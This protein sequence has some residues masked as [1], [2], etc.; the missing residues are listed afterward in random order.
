M[1]YTNRFMIILITISSL[2]S[3]QRED[4]KLIIEPKWE[5]L[6][7]NTDSIK[8]F[9]GKWVLAGSII[10]KKKSSECVTL[11][12]IHLKWDG[13]FIENLT[14]SLYHKQPNKDFHP[15]Q[16]FLICDGIWNKKKQMLILNFDKHCSLG[17]VNT[18]YLVLT[19]PQTQES[20]IKKG[21]FKLVNTC[22]PHQFKDYLGNQN[23]HLSLNSP[24][25]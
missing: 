21:S 20:L 16:D 1:K 11:H 19:I 22:L 23:I 7:T 2:S 13:P 24:L 4:F 15:I 9:G 10:F 18:F 17:P 25:R 6:D 14:G 8:K 3:A 5:N 12:Q